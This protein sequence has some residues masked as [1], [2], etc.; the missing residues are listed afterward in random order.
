[1]KTKQKEKKLTDKINAPELETGVHPELVARETA[2]RAYQLFVER[3]CTHGFDMQDW[4]Q[5][6]QEMALRYS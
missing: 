2:I 1:M 6:E 4:L 3:G 5:A